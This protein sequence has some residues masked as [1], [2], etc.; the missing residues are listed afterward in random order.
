MWARLCFMGIYLIK[1]KIKIDDS[2]D[3]FG[4]RGGLAVELLAD[5]KINPGIAFH[6]W[7]MDAFF[8]E[9]NLGDLHLH[10]A[11]SSGKLCDNLR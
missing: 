2:L 10:F 1:F 8:E 3:A 7:Q 9:T 4:V 5:N 6:A 11:L